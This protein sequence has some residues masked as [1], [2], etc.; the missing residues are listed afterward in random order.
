[1]IMEIEELRQKLNDMVEACDCGCSEVL[2]LSREM[3]KLIVIYL[4]ERR[5]Q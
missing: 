5:Q 4:Q 1:M 3:D 2:E